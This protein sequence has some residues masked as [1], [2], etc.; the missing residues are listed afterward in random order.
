MAWWRRQTA[1]V[2][3]TAVAAVVGPDA[4]EVGARRLRV[5]D[6]WC[7]TFAVTGYPASLP[8]A[9]LETILSWP[10]RLDVAIHVE[11]MPAEHA[12]SR[13]RRQRARL[14]STR[15]MDADRGRLGDP[16]VEA[17][18]VDAADLADRVARGADRL[19]RAGIYVTVHASSPQALAEACAQ[20]RAAAAGLLLELQPVTYRQVQGWSSTLPLATDTVGVR[21][22]LDSYALAALLPIASPDLPAPLPGDPLPTTALLY[23]LNSDSNGL[24]M[25]DRWA[26]PNHNSV[27][28]AP[29]GSGKSFHVKLE[30]LRSLYFGVQARI[31][32][33]EDEYV[34]LA[35]H[36]DGTVVQLGAPGVKLNPFDLP[37]GDR[38]PDALTRRALF[39][40][41][42]VAVMTG[43]SLPPAETAALDKAILSA[44]R[45]AGITAD[46]ATW[47]RPA[48][49][50]TD[51]HAVLAADTDPAAR[52]LA[53]RLTPWVSG[54]FAGLF[55]APTTTR[56]DGACVVWSLRHLPAELHTIGSLLAL[57]SIWRSIDTPTPG[58]RRSPRRLVVVDEAW[59][60]LRQPAAALWLA[61]LAKAARK[62]R[63]GVAVVSQDIADVLGSDLGQAVINNSA[64]QILMGQ[65]PQTI[66]TVAH[67]FGLTEVER[68][69]LLTARQGEALLLSGALRIP[70]Q[71]VADEDEYPLVATDQPSE[72]GDAVAVVDDPDLF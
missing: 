47:G 31:V 21:R 53:A 44:Y 37:A 71:V 61:K 60:M 22:T 63:A 59:T 12:A 54:S 9:S 6:G 4:V 72:T 13:L 35:R 43:Q 19:F 66:D 40:H 8:A 42:V 65:S 39:L 46:P 29:S 50:V 2:A 67:A 7:A 56:P 38:R 25:W 32:D 23:G 48:P 68:Q 58:G 16:Q 70:F 18:A 11:P 27:I 55:D 17:A 28:L 41:T 34:A 64:T 62:R 24:V 3:G 52:T 57:D 69:R 49:L 5:G 33:P 36:V 20:V 30:T 15:R 14:E 26:L 10:G 45:R 51:L 1:A